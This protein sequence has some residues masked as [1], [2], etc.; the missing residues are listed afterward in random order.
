[1]SVEDPKGFGNPSG[2]VIG[3]CVRKAKIPQARGGD[4]DC[5]VD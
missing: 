4:V 5:D 1:M 3:C 2:L